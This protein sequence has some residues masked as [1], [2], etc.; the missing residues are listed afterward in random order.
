MLQLCCNTQSLC[1]SIAGLLYIA[2]T[3]I[4]FFYI[5]IWASEFGEIIILGAGIWSCICWWVFGFCCPLW[6]F[7]KFGG[8]IFLVG[9]YSGI[10]IIVA[11]GTSR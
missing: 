9:N 11:I 5:G 4:V 8:S 6:F 7:V 3:V 2:L 10:P 1:G